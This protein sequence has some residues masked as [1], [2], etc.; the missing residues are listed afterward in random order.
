MAALPSASLHTPS[1]RGMEADSLFLLDEAVPEGS[2]LIDPVAVGAILG[3]ADRAWVEAEDI[4]VAWCW[5]V[6]LLVRV[7]IDQS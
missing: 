6:D 5:L 1:L 4:R 3:D 7:P 2:A